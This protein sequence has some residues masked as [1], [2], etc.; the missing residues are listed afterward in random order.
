MPATWSRRALLVS[1]GTASLAGLA[2]CTD[3]TANARGATD[4]VLHN[5]ARGRRTVDVRVTSGSDSTEA[6]TDS[7]ELESNGRHTINNEVLMGSNYT[8]QITVSG[9]STEAYTEA[10]EWTA[11]GKP[12]H[13][14]VNDQIVFAIQVG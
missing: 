14:I 7:F 4:I 2:G 8:V 9:E 13:V 3:S 6:F 10:Y 1:A 11:A 12:L 5:E